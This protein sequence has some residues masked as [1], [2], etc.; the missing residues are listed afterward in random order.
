M[1]SNIDHD[2]FIK[3]SQSLKLANQVEEFLQS[4]ALT[5]TTQIPFGQ[6]SFRQGVSN[7][8]NQSPL[9]KATAQ[10]AMRQ[11]M[12]NSIQED[13]VKK[14]NYNKSPV[15]VISQNARIDFNRSARA[16][17]F[18]AGLK[19]FIGICK[20]VNHGQTEFAIKNDGNEHVCKL[21]KKEIAAEWNLK[22]KVGKV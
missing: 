11:I 5:E 21:C 15:A 14:S 13:R 9:K 7:D 20:K 18:K 6:S 2:V 19:V 1:N 12:T 22:R 10:D 8:W 17:A 4:K 3:K 16:K